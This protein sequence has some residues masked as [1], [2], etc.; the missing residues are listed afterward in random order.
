MQEETQTEAFSF[1]YLVGFLARKVQSND[2]VISDPGTCALSEGSARTDLSEHALCM[3]N[4][5]PSYW[6]SLMLM[7]KKIVFSGPSG[8]QNLYHLDHWK[9]DTIDYYWG[10]ERQFLSSYWEIC[11]YLKR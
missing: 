11:M 7:K 2:P 4:V 3:C 8:L 9:F 5:L 1:H 6:A 10:K